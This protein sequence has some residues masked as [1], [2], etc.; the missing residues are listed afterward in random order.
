MALRY[1]NELLEGFPIPDDGISFSVLNAKDITPYIKIGNAIV[2]GS[3]G[4]ETVTIELRGIVTPPFEKPRDAD[5]TDTFTYRSRTWT[6]INV[7]EGPT[8]TIAGT[9]AY[10]T[11]TVTGVD[12]E[13]PT[14]TIV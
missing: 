10:R 12:L 11:W 14:V 5:Y 7:L 6:V 1:V 2:G 8:Y 9:R 3:Y 4:Y 13:N